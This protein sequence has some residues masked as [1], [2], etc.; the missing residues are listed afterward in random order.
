MKK[1]KNTFEKFPEWV[2]EKWQNIADL[3]AETIGIPAALIMKT[4]N[5]FMEVF[6]SSH[7]ENNP[8]QVG[9]KE[10]RYGLYCENVIKTQNKLSVP[11][12]T[13]DKVW[14]KNPDIKLGMISYLGFPLNFPDNQPFG[15]LCILDNKERQFTL[16]NEKLIQQFKNV[17]ELDLA[18]LQSFELK[19][20][21]LAAN[22][23]NEIAKL[24]QVEKIL[25]ENDKR[26][27][28]L[29]GNLEAGI[30]VHAP[31]TSVIMNN[32]RASELFGLS[33][34]QMKGKVANDPAWKFVF[35]NYTAVPY[36]QYPV[37]RIVKS[38]K[39]FRNQVYG[40]NQPDKSDIVWLMVNGFP[41][42][43]S[44]GNITEI[45]ISFIDITQRKQAEDKH[46]LKNFVFDA[47]IAANSIADMNGIITEANDSFLR[48]W[49]YQSKNEV[50]G[51]E[52]AFFI[53]DPDAA[54]TIITALNNTGDWEGDY[55]ARKK[56]GST[57]VAHGLATV[58][59]DVTGK[60]IAYQSAVVDIT[61]SKKSEAELEESREKYRGLS[62]AAF[63]SIFISEKGICI[64][65]NKSAE[66]MFG[67]TS[68]EAIGK[69]GTEWIASQD[70]EMVM[71][72]MLEGLEEPYEGMALK[73]DGTTF[74]CILQ[75][76]MM[77][78]K[79]R[80]VRVTSLTDNTHR[81][82]AEENLKE[83]ELRYRNLFDHANEGLILLTMD[84]KIAELNQSFAQM[85]GYTVDEMKNM[86]IK[87]LDVLREATFDSREEIM[88]RILAGEVVRFEV[89]HYHKDGHSFF[90]NDTVSLITISG[91]QY[92]LAFHQ[93][94]TEHKRAEEELRNSENN[95]KTLFNE[96]TDGITIFSI[97]GD[98]VAPVIVDMNENAASMLGYS[99]EEMI[100][101]DPGKLEIDIT[102][103]KME[104]RVEELKT[105]GFLNYETT[106]QHKNGNK[107]I[108]EIKTLVINYANQPAVMNIAR[109]ITKR[110]EI[111]QELI[112]AKE[113]AEESEKKYR[114]IFDNTFDIM[115][116][117]EVTEDGRFKVITFNPAEEKLIGSLENYQ[118]R[119]IDECIPPE[120]YNEFKP[121]Y[122]RCIQEEKLIVYEE[123]IS[124]QDIHKTFYTQLIPLKNNEGRVHR[125]IVI[126]RDITDVKLLSTQLTHQNEELKLLNIDLTVSKEK[127]E[128]SD[129]LKTA[130]LSNMAHEIRTPMNGILGFSELLQEPG[131]SDDRQ[132]E[133]L[134]IIEKSGKRMLNIIDEIVEISK[135]EAGVMPIEI[136]DTVINEKIEF[137]Y[138]L[139]KPEAEARGLKLSVGNTLP[140]KAATI[141]SD[142]QKIY[143][144]L[145][146]LVK[147]AIKYTDKGSVEFGYDVVETGH[148]LSL[149]FYV[150]DTG[151]GIPKDRQEA[152][153]ERFIQ[154][155]IIDI[156]ARQGAGLGLSIAKAYVELLGGKI[157]VESEEGIGSTFYFTLPYIFETERKNVDKT[158][159]SS[160]IA[161]NI[162]E[163]L[164]ILIAEDDKTSEL[165]LGISVEKFSQEILKARTGIEAVEICR[166]NPD[167][168]L[169]LMDIQMPVLDGY[170]ATH[171]IR[172]FN[173]NVVIIAQTSFGLSGDR[174]KSIAA[175][176][177]DYI[178]KPVRRADLL[179]LIQKYFMK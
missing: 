89:E 102:R 176:C 48:V 139:L 63:E 124:F 16:L 121:H 85:H 23:V 8:Y 83:S 11:N 112:T 3:L 179:A 138:E 28:H 168:D 172:Q 84:G 146:N 157:R 170:K 5:E 13:K 109:D 108:V 107:I 96:N 125:I 68:E 71:Q 126:S 154:A 127:A 91:Q 22:V 55:T 118:N 111:E 169:I 15:T 1:I 132:Q 29:I 18:L 116:I 134:K 92:F 65:Q 97:R 66:N 17:I 73:K 87:D 52:I 2:I 49:G 174:E 40:I 131:L 35:E 37:N 93:D 38:K 32:S 115:S 160:D 24:K 119:Y 14:N 99:W 140:Q 103:E 62:E 166:N 86:D 45:V 165:L 67:Y 167:I 122:D 33:D 57:F 105:K 173:K 113:N 175:G 159:W 72:H 177:D 53:D 41:E 21:E 69:Y 120:L 6:I 161:N 142:G 90:M 110:K 156:Q 30:V 9:S 148:G 150:K 51:K 7:S 117:Y 54:E 147:N 70:R 144:I 163:K 141:K 128:E 79:G 153:F 25:Q 178:A 136:K 39:P 95:Y 164:K 152:I 145:S 135:I 4:E 76:K 143:S 155:D 98:E 151:I 162:S 137:I 27:L 104:K 94:I 61:D 12:A 56:N 46:R 78:Y 158:D 26:N 123:D 100:K 47:S 101:M 44:K 75:G 82:Q 50:I 31:D 20:S 74:P 64:D 80:T 81:K 114:Q 149:Q 58:V 129:K 42:L 59:K 19:T 88:Q 77:H 43:N 130:F 34:F 36:D 133:Y 60:T 171:Q 10:K 106:L